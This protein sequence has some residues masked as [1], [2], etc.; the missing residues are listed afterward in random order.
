[1]KICAH[2]QK[3]MLCV[4]NGIY[5]VWHKKH[6]YCGNL[7]KCQ[8]CNSEIIVTNRESTF[9]TELEYLRYKRDFL[10]LDMD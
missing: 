3:E 9:L 10:V 4:K 8:H 7:Y 2:C 5:A 1:M 6:A